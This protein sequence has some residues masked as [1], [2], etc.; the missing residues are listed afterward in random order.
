ME[1]VSSGL[2]P[3]NWPYKSVI[4]R[5]YADQPLDVLPDEAALAETDEQAKVLR[6]QAEAAQR[7]VKRLKRPWDYHY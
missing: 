3:E 6:A 7:E 4:Q 2:L 1:A 5:F